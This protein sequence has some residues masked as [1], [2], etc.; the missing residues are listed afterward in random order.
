MTKPIPDYLANLS[1]LL[2]S[3][4]AGAVSVAGLKGSAP[5]YLLSRLIQESS[6]PLV[7]ITADQEGAE[8]LCRELRY[9]AARPEEILPFPSWDVTPFEAASPHP[10]IVGERLNAL[11]RLLDG[12]ARAV[13]APLA[14]ALQRVIPR[15]TLGEVCQYLL[16]G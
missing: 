4:E 16:T 8:E 11:A 10:D 12:R 9:F 3:A 1:T 5:A 14:S 2:Q 7:V 13:V 6:A 15:Q